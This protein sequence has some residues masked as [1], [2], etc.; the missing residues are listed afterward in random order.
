MANN[1]NDSLL[2]WLNEDLLLNNN[3]YTDE[4]LL[5]I[6]DTTIAEGKNFLFQNNFIENN[7]MT[8]ELETARQTCPIL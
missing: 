3:K 2:W 6:E 5:D 7:I 1:H 8:S 4:E